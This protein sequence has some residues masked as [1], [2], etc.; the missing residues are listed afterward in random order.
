VAVVVDIKDRR[1]I[2]V[3]RHETLSREDTVVME[4]RSI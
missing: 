2:V 1:R 3:L 4:R